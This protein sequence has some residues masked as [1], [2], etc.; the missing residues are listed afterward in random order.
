LTRY[1]GEH[2]VWLPDG[3]GILYENNGQLWVISIDGEE[4]QPVR[5]RVRV[6]FG[7]EPYAVPFQIP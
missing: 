3:S 2:P 7:H 6:I 1:G 4:N 5:F